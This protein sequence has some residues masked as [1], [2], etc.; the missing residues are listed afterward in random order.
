[1]TEAQI[2]ALDDAVKRASSDRLPIIRRVAEG[3]FRGGKIH[4]LSDPENRTTVEVKPVKH[5]KVAMV[6]AWVGL[7]LDGIR[8]FADGLVL[9]ERLLS[10]Q[11]L[12][13][14]PVA[15]PPDSD[16]PYVDLFNILVPLTFADPAAARSQSGPVVG[17]D[18]WRIEARL[19]KAI[20]LKS[21]R[22][23]ELSLRDC[24]SPWAA[25]LKLSL[26][27]GEDRAAEFIY[28]ARLSA[29][30]MLPEQRKAVQAA[31]SA[32]QGIEAAFKGAPGA[33]K[34]KFDYLLRLLNAAKNLLDDTLSSTMTT[35][36]PENSSPAQ[37][38]RNSSS[39]GPASTRDEALRKLAEAADYFR[40]VEP[41]SPIPLLI[42][43]VQ[44][45]AGLDFA[46]LIQELEL[47]EGAV[48]EFR[49]QAGI[50]EEASK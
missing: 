44:T 23:G 12:T 46:R 14:H 38:V 7:A 3:L 27:G 25:S 32:L 20:F 21:D 30:S 4:V 39:G 11:W 37:G 33:L 24:L 2:S 16:E 36:T 42:K 48:K 43:R 50:R 49:K 31:I 1:V 10:S 9:M 28:E 13:L 40:R 19:L 6:L 35:E 15:E 22:H 41:S 18:S 45:L 26:P 5:L 29:A 34:P 47:G 17:S 8:G